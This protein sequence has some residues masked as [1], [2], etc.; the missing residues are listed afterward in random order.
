MNDVSAEL[1]LK[2]FWCFIHTSIDK[3]HTLTCRW[4]GSSE[5]GH[6]RNS[7]L[8]PVARQP[9]PHSTWEANI[10]LRSA[11]V[12]GGMP[13]SESRH[14]KAL[15]TSATTSQVHEECGGG[16]AGT[17]N[18]PEAPP[19]LDSLP[20]RKQPCSLLLCW[21]IFSPWTCFPPWQSALGSC[22]VP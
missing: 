15:L 2:S 14:R 22:F 13:G 8:N 12:Q 1:V 9:G 5:L 20:M 3:S 10:R 6:R 11:A 21:S 19:A 7:M 18:K 16:G 17:P 4:Y